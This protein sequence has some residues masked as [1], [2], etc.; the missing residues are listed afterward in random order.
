MFPIIESQTLKNGCPMQRH[1]AYTSHTASWKF[2]SQLGHDLVRLA[3]SQEGL[4]AWLASHG[5]TIAFPST[6]TRGLSAEMY[7]DTEE[8]ALM[9][10][11]MTF[12]IDKCKSVVGR[13]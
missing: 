2:V 6:A 9:N 11:A 13:A 12:E 5:G 1:S 3:E 8:A 10:A 7:G 4:E